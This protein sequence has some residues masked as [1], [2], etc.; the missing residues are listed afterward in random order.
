MK[1]RDLSNFTQLIC[2]KAGSRTQNSLPL[3]I[4]KSIKNKFCLN[5]SYL[6]PTVTEV[7]ELV[8]KARKD[9]GLSS[10]VQWLMPVG[11]LQF[12]ASLGK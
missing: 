7:L 10:Q 5:K 12:K 11:E 4:S 2:D 1:G 6:F 9:F 8:P 3:F